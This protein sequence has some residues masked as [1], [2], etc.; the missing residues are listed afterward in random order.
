[1]SFLIYSRPRDKNDSNLNYSVSL[2][3]FGSTQV[4]L[5][6]LREL[7]G[8]DEHK[9]IMKSD[10]VN[11]AIR[12]TNLQKP[13]LTLRDRRHIEFLGTFTKCIGKSNCV[14][15]AHKGN[16]SN[17]INIVVERRERRA[18]S[19]FHLLIGSFWFFSHV[20]FH[21]VN[22]NIDIIKLRL[23]PRHHHSLLTVHL[24]AMSFASRRE[25]NFVFRCNV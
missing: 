19:H 9:S 2:S 13:T 5:V 22:F 18:T 23:S 4:D 8:S 10:Y 7:P 25:V 24:N 17:L 15:R 20:M 6:V 16:D 1:M 12:K 14:R 3:L 21:C 11:Q